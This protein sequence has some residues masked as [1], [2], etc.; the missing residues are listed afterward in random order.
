MNESRTPL[1]RPIEDGDVE[2]V[3]ALW[4][5]CDLTRAH[6][7]PHKD[8]AFARAGP[9]SEVLVGRLDGAIVASVMVGHDGHRGA[10]Y[11]VACDPE[12]QG[13]GL[14]RATMAAAEDWLRSKGV[15]KLNLMIRDGNE[16]VRG[17]Y[18]ALGYEC[19]PRVVMSRRL[20]K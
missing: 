2:E 4:R 17:F 11:Y 18:D 9:G 12:R 19:E 20:E 10:V 8:I 16:T 5:K 1:F 13:S 14:G 15:W 7:D 3:V 6:N